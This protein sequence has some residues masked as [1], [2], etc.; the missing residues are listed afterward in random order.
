MEDENKLLTTFLFYFSIISV[1]SILFILTMTHL[2]KEQIF[3]SRGSITS[4]E[5]FLLLG[6]FLVFFFILTSLLW[7]LTEWRRN[8]DSASGDFVFLLMGLFCLVCT[9][10]EKVLAD[11][12]GR[13]KQLGWETTGEL[14]IFNI[15]LAIQL[16]YSILMFA[17]LKRKIH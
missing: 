13:E 3:L 10:G 4:I 2:N 17:K 6:F 9:G 11:E 15:L 7:L 16:L 1:I 8:D 14:I 5:L 12:I